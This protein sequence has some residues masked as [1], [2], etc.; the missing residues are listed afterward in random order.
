MV[1]YPVC[2]GE[3]ERRDVAATRREAALP[4]AAREKHHAAIGN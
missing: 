3:H 1:L 4:P 2:R